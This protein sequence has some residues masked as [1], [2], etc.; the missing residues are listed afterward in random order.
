[1][2]SMVDV[3]ASMVYVM[4]PMVDVIWSMVEGR[5][6]MIYVISSI[7]ESIPIGDARMCVV[8]GLT[9]HRLSR[10]MRKGEI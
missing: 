8:Q 7:V 6:S 2:R 10:D 9:Y 3:C 5:W 4:G 1:M